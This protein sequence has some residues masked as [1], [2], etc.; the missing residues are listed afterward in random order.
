MGLDFPNPVGLAAGLD[1]QAEHVD[2]LAALGFG[3]L[4]LGTRHAAPAAGQPAA[5]PVPHARRRSALINRMGF[6]NVGVDAFVE[7]LERA[8]WRGV[9]GINIGKNKDTP[10]TTRPPTTTR[11]AWRSVYAHATT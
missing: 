4:E 3:F 10:I 11:P 9:L 5:A 6:N 1:K 8:S 2:A 7:N